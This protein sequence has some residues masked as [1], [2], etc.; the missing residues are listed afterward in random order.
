MIEFLGIV[1]SIPFE[2]VLIIL[3][4]SAVGS[5]GAM[6]LLGPDFFHDIFLPVVI[7]VGAVLVGL[8]AGIE[9][10]AVVVIAG[11]I[12]MLGNRKPPNGYH[13]FRG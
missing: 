6:F 12:A 2:H 4:L 13:H 5:I 8:Y 1:L 10:G 9:A 7:L 3:G 11:I